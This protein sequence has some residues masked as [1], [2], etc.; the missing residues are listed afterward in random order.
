MCGGC[1]CNSIPYRSYALCVVLRTVSVSMF[2]I[3]RFGCVLLISS[4]D[5]GIVN[6]IQQQW[7]SQPKLNW[8]YNQQPAA[9]AVKMVSAERLLPLYPSCVQ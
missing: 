7:S 8:H 9:V 1:D 5:N 4:A 2:S 3:S 6:E